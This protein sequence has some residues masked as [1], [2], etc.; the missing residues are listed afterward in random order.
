MSFSLNNE[1]LD[2]IKKLQEDM[3]YIDSKQKIIPSKLPPIKQTMVGSEYV[4]TS[5]GNLHSS[6]F[7]ELEKKITDLCRSITKTGKSDGCQKPNSP[8][9]MSTIT[10]V[11]DPFDMFS[12]VMGYECGAKYEKNNKA[13][14]KEDFL[15]TSTLLNQAKKTVRD[16]D[17]HLKR[18]SEKVLPRCQS[19]DITCDRIKR[20]EDVPLKT[21]RQFDPS[22]KK[23][24][25]E[26]FNKNNEE[27]KLFPPSKSINQKKNV[28]LIEFSKNVSK[29][30]DSQQQPSY[31]LPILPKLTEKEDEGKSDISKVN[32]NFKTKIVSD[33]N[34]INDCKFKNLTVLQNPCIDVKPDL[35]TQKLA[36]IQI[37]SDRNKSLCNCKTNV[38]YHEFTYESELETSCKCQSMIQPKI[39]NDKVEA[40]KEIHKVICEMLDDTSKDS[41]DDQLISQLQEIMAKLIETKPLEFEDLNELEN[42]VD[43]HSVIGY[44]KT[45]IK[46]K[47]LEIAKHLHENVDYGISFDQ[48]AAEIEKDAHLV[49]KR[50]DKIKN[51][52]LTINPSIECPDLSNNLNK[53]SNIK[54]AQDITNRH[55]INT[56]NTKNIHSD[57]HVSAGELLRY[58]SNNF[59][60]PKMFKSSTVLKEFDSPTLLFTDCSNQNPSECN[61]LTTQTEMIYKN[62]S[63]KKYQLESENVHQSKTTSL[64]EYGILSHLSNNLSFKLKTQLMPFEEY[65]NND[66]KNN[67]TINEKNWEG[68]NN[69]NINGVDTDSYTTNNEM[70]LMRCN[71][72]TNHE[73]HENLLNN[74]KNTEHPLINSQT[75]DLKRLSSNIEECEEW[76]LNSLLLTPFPFNSIQQTNIPINFEKDV[77]EDSTTSTTSII[78]STMPSKQST[79]DVQS[80]AESLI[81]FGEINHINKFHNVYSDSSAGEIK[82][83]K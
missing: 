80:D 81:S 56:I 65:L 67:F 60:S 24:S 76:N 34:E 70:E 7:V 43:E 1:Q 45:A 6:N 16:T 42:F 18:L 57:K 40:R 44:S 15:K 31:T 61:N 39:T 71:L 29:A 22:N 69:L 54:D 32:I 48:L 28:N 72:L 35:I 12:K 64:G 25:S 14:I 23:I 73:E 83:K 51:S 63:L 52:I 17:W 10:T 8:N 20:Y 79:Q 38:A 36:N 82:N 77:S 21:K 58:Y 27:S 13:L 68:D 3:K 75:M 53:F 47:L 50:I 46:N 9:E 78:S 26:Y 41:L 19:A 33:K 59:S 74:N 11:P 30:N 37:V 5:K 4:R 66:Q 2:T 62:N 55:P 49:L